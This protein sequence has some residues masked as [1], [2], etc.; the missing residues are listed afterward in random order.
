MKLNELLSDND[1]KEALA[2]LL[3]QGKPGSDA[4]FEFIHGDYSEFSKAFK[5][6]VFGLSALAGNPGDANTMAS[7]LS[8]MSITMGT[9]D[10]ALKKK[11]GISNLEEKTK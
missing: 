3:A 10:L 2:E 6:V 7:I 5:I 8:A 9:I 11:Y 4:S 1:L